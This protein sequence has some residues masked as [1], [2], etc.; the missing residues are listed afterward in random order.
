MYVWLR[1]ARMAA[2]TK[3]PRPLSAR[4]REPAFVPLPAD[5]HRFQP[6]SQQCPLPDAGRSRP[7][8][9]LFPLRPVRADAPEE[10]GADARRRADRVRAR[11]QALAA[12]RGRVL[13]RDLGGHA[14]HR[15]HQFILENGEIAALVHDHS[16]HLRPQRTALRRDGR[17]DPAARHRRPTPRPPSEA[18]KIFMASHTGLRALAKQGEGD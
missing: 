9:H 16:R 6:P 14:G 18:E 4:R 13:D 8:R 3:K 15:Q 17:S 7:H 11:D 5:R 2:T 1:F 10:L 12:L